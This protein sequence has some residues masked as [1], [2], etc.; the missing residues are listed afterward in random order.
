M[1]LGCLHI[2]V[3]CRFGDK[4]IV[5]KPVTDVGAK[6]GVAGTGGVRG[7]FV[8]ECHIQPRC[9]LCWPW[10]QDGADES[11]LD[12]AI[13]G[14]ALEGIEAATSGRQCV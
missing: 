1:G 5:A 7:H 12:K 4:W 9:R 2:H 6:Y 13:P 8:R 10:E 14:H 11:Q 3:Q